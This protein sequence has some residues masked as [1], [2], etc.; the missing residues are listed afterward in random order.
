MR[1]LEVSRHFIPAM[2]DAVQPVPHHRPRH[3][4]PRLANEDEEGGLEGVFRVGGA[5]QDAAADAPHHRAVA[6]QQ[7]L[8]GGL[9]LPLDVAPQESGVGRA[10]AVAG[11]RPA[12]EP[13]KN[14]A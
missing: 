8:E 7:R 3:D 2:S 5:G 11:A 1:G 12:A 13:P 10:F 9:V 14:S 6:H 4:G